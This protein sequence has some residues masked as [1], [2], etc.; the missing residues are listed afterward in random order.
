[1]DGYRG[2]EYLGVPL[3]GTA[4]NAGDLPDLRPQVVRNERRRQVLQRLE[5]DHRIVRQSAAAGGERLL[6]H[7]RGVEMDDLV[8]RRDV[9]RRTRRM[10]ADPVEDIGDL[11]LTP[12]SASEHARLLRRDRFRCPL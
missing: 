9:L 8:Q 2:G 3:L 6:D 10:R 5:A 7:H 11:R 4:Q 12:G 1:M